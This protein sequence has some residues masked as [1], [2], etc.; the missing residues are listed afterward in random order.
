MSKIFAIAV[1]ELKSYFGS[2]L[3]YLVFIL[4]VSTFNI[5]FYVIV[6]ENQEATLRDIFKVM[7]FMFVFLVPLITMRSFSEEKALGTMEFLLTTP[8]RPSQIVW[9]K[10]W[11]SYLFFLMMASVIAIYYGII[12][13][14]AKGDLGASLTGFLGIA[15][16]GAFF[17]SVGLWA[18]SVTRSQTVAAMISYF[19]LFILYFSMA[20]T[21]HWGA[22]GEKIIRQLG[23]FSHL[24]NLSAG[25]LNTSDIIYYIS[26]IAVCLLWTNWNIDKRL[27]R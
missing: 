23:V 14:F 6:D 26:A 11:G 4:T 10:F 16:E 22:M 17:I 21:K 13:S 2:F 25:L 3:P 18:S 20:L 12:A 9:G 15:L 24:D 19:V 5:F 27:W 1:K 8:T 7:E